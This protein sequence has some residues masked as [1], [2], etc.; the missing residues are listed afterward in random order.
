MFQLGILQ[1]LVASM[2]GCGSLKMPVSAISRINYICNHQK[3]V[4]GLKFGDRQN[5]IN[6]TISTGVLD[7]EPDLRDLNNIPNSR[8]GSNAIQNDILIDEDIDEETSAQTNA[9]DSVHD[10][11]D[12]DCIIDDASEAD[13]DNEPN[14]EMNE[15]YNVE[16]TAVED[17]A[18]EIG[19]NSD[20]EDRID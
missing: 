17:R 6:A 3:S 18:E 8:I 10:S 14:E 7:N 9:G 15:D 19:I 11:D 20:E 5:Q 2:E 13:E 16:T 1:N 4:K 12:T